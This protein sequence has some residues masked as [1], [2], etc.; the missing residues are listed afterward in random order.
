MAEEFVNLP[1]QLSA[2][3]SECGESGVHTFEEARTIVK[4]RFA[5]FHQL[6][7]DREEQLLSCLDRLES[8]NRTKLE[9]LQ[10]DLRSLEL[11][12]QMSELNLKSNNLA[13]IMKSQKQLFNSKI[14][15]FETKKLFLNKVCLKWEL[16]GT[17]FE[18]IAEVSVFRTRRQERDT[19]APLLELE[20]VE[21]ERWYVVPE[22]WFL[23]W[24]QAVN[25]D[26]SDLTSDNEVMENIPID[27]ASILGRDL[28]SV[29]ITTLHSDAWKQLLGWHGLAI[30]SVQISI[31]THS[32]LEPT[33]Q[34][35]LRF[36]YKVLRNQI[37][38]NVNY[39]YLYPT[40]TFQ[41]VFD[42]VTQDISTEKQL[43]TMFCKQKQSHNLLRFSQIGV[44][45]PLDNATIVS[46][47]SRPI[48]TNTNLKFYFNIS[49]KLRSCHSSS[50]C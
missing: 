33:S 20:P 13:E 7:G 1:S 46:D 48:G 42:V 24:K 16:N 44:Y 41:D 4:S 50:S 2:D 32:K 31:T 47:F 49:N 5:T 15:E 21:G 26:S 22:S 39:I 36:C 27:N 34:T 40:Q 28:D 35:K 25:F 10:E 8:I 38:M 43:I 6:L 9:P 23:Q 17:V 18:R 30:G 29:A 12:L 45:K 37:L 19:I 3:I 14:F 11:T